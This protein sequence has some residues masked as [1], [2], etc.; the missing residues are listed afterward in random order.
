[1]SEINIRPSL[2]VVENITSLLDTHVALIAR[3]AFLSDPSFHR[4]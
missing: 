4:E 3:L 1:M 2:E